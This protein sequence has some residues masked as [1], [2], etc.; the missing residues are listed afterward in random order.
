MV[1]TTQPVAQPE[2]RPKAVHRSRPAGFFSRFQAFVLDLIILGLAEL[3]ASSFTQMV[4]TFFR[5]TGLS[6]AL[7]RVVSNTT[8]DSVLLALFV[9][10]YFILSWTLV[11]FTPGKA[12]LGLKVEQTG[13]ARISFWRALLRFVGYW[14]SALPLFLGFLW[15][16]WDSDREGWHDKIASTRVLYTPKK[17]HK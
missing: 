15:V 7:E 16:I 8:V 4:L 11:G 14:I 6:A 17:P 12:I 3:V 9:S 1:S 13:G 2:R 5:F 10:S